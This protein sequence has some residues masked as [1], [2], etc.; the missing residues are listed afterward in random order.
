MEVVH[1]RC[2]GLDVHKR[3]VVA[4][5]I[6][7][8]V[9]QRRKFGTVTSELVAMRDWL[10]SLGVTHVAMEST[11]PYWKP[12]FNLLE[13]SGIEAL[14]VNAAHIKAVPGRKTDMNDAQWIAELLRHGLLKASFIPDRGQREL[15][16]LVRYRRSLIQERAREI[17]RIQKV[18][19]GAN[20][21]LASVA[22][23]VMGVSGRAMLEALTTG[24]TDPEELAGLA[25]GRLRDKHD[26]LVQ[27]L[28]GLMGPHQRFILAEQLAHIDEID[29]RI[30]R[31][32][33]EI[34]RRTRPFAEQLRALDEIPG[35][36]RR[37]AEELIAEIG[38]DMSRFPTVRHIASWARLCP[39]T[40]ESAGKRRSGAT[41]H[42]NPW[43]RATLVEA[44]IA[45]GRTKNTYPSAQLRRLAARRG[46]KRAAVAVAH[47]ILAIAY[48][49]LK[50]RTPYADL[51][52]TYFD[53][54]SRTAIAAKAKRR[55]ESLG[56]EVTIKEAA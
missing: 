18:L 53:H 45:A 25:K 36:G 28:E 54:R 13:D 30:A 21:K 27:A 55:L 5:A 38:V 19:E 16:E 24:Q 7:D 4:A 20:I 11:G 39:G 44:A 40:N 33:E 12:V 50:T 41:G 8:G 49:I 26:Q 10:L 22:S 15:R 42:G 56:Y 14:V 6:V 52:S 37:S 43:L 35:M 1:E 31:L 48:T 23:K 47:S 51:G 2:A 3:V 29:G 46:Y 32:S 34:E 17:A 9:R